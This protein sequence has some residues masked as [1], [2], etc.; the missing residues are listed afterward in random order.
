MQSVEHYL[1]VTSHFRCLLPPA[2][3]NC[4]PLHSTENISLVCP[5]S[6]RCTA[7]H[8]TSRPRH[9]HRHRH[10]RRQFHLHLHFHRHRHFN[11]SSVQ[12]SSMSTPFLFASFFLHTTPHQCTSHHFTPPHFTSGQTTALHIIRHHGTPLHTTA[13]PY[14]F[15]LIRHPLS[16]IPCPLSLISYL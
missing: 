7:R 2:T 1:N 8:V 12:F 13:L 6:R 4:T 5:A 15:T 16:F 3:S 9:R 10:R 14:L 11:F